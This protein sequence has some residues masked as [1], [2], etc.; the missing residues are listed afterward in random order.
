MESRVYNVVLQERLDQPRIRA[1]RHA[2]VERESE[3]L[4]ATVLAYDPAQAKVCTSFRPACMAAG[5]T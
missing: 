3:L 5:S 1:K 4:V 2:C